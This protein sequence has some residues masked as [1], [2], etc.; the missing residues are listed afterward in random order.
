M[1]TK[2]QEIE[3]ILNALGRNDKV[4]G[5]VKASHLGKILNYLQMKGTEEY[6]KTL[7]KMALVCGANIRY[8]RE[9]Y[10]KGLEMFGII[11]V[12]HSHNITVWKWIGD[13]AFNNGDIKEIIEPEESATD[14]MKRKDKEKIKGACEVCGK[15]T[16]ENNRF[17]SS[18]C[19]KK[20]RG[21][22]EG[23]K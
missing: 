3:N 22:K 5:I 21:K 17:C 4:E 8:I 20:Y 13:K 6:E 10:L 19:I 16:I 2:P 23:D 18:A 14:Y 7:Y 9:N 15:P 11:S 1:S 12:T